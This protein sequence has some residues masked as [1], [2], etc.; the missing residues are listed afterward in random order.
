MSGDRWVAWGRRPHTP[1]LALVGLLVVAMAVVGLQGRDSA[2]PRPVEVAVD[3]G[4]AA[5]GPLGPGAAAPASGLLP[6]TFTDPVDPEGPGDPAPADPGAPP[7]VTGARPTTAATSAVAPSATSP[8]RAGDPGPTSATTPAR[9]CRNATE[10]DCGD[11]RWDPAPMPNQPLVAAFTTAPATAVVGRPA[12]FEVSWSDADAALSYDRLTTGE[13][14][15]NIACTMV[16]RFGP[17]TPPAPAPSS[18]NLRYTPTFPAPG[19]YAVTVS[20]DTAD[21]TS[22]YGS[23]KLLNT[24]IVVTG[25]PG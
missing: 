7:A 8:A 1:G 10:P 11:F 25:A 6:P 5:E 14:V 19:T 4:G 13:P 17:W 9:V 15:L 23:G 2:E 12:P 21:C 3:R 22:P 16:A 24:T 18:G 20:L